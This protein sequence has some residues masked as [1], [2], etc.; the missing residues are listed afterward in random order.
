[1]INGKSVLAI[2]PARGGSKRLPE[3][4]IKALC[5]KPLIA[6]SIEQARGCDDID[7]IVVSTEDENIAKVAKQ[8]GAEVPFI[9]PLELATDTASTIDVISH[10]IDWLE[11]KES[12][13]P[14]YIVLLQAT[15]PL[16][17][18]EDIKGA[19][20]TLKEKYA[21]AV[22]SVCETDKHPWRS[23]TLPENENMKD[24]LRAQILNKH[25]QDLPIFYQLNGAI[26]LAKMNYLRACNGFHGPDTF[27]YKMVKERSID[28]DS[29]LDFRIAESLFAKR[30]KFL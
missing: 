11:E 25:R 29:E 17:V 7:R 13:R 20:Q 4:N 18:V 21:Q 16:R 3:K 10:A 9:R 23:N 12:Y 2:I 8:F 30:K 22:V 15:S 1:V 14:E 6:W 24:F 19:I 5:G 26:Y 28:I 27:A